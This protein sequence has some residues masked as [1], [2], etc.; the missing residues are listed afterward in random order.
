MVLDSINYSPF[1]KR[2]DV[3]D[4]EAQSRKTHNVS[5]YLNDSRLLVQ[6]CKILNWDSAKLLLIIR[7]PF[8]SL[9]LFVSVSLSLVSNVDIIQ[10]LS[11]ASS[12]RSEEEILWRFDL[13]SRGNTSGDDLMVSGAHGNQRGPRENSNNHIFM[14]FLL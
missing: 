2:P 7:R 13:I 11:V 12:L 14:L 10:L 4:L 8:W 9:R 1:L 6:I 3:G 5:F